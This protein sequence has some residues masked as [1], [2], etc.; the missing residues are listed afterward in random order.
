MGRLY[1]SIRPS[2]HTHTIVQQLKNWLHGPQFK[3]KLG[4]NRKLE[5]TLA[6]ETLVSLSPGASLHAVGV[7]ICEGTA[8][9]DKSDIHSGLVTIGFPT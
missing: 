3:D 4:D 2:T 9:S 5:T 8:W 7:Q 6:A 1:D